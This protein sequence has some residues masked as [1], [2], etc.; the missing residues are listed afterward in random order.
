MASTVQI[1]AH[2]SL[3]T[4]ERLERLVRSLGT[5]RTH[6]IEQALLHHLRALEELPPD[7][8]VPARLVLDEASADRVRDLVERPPEA[9]EELRRLLDDD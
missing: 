9:T 3:A 2:V 8:A 6:L 1:S 7:A 5:T 4:K